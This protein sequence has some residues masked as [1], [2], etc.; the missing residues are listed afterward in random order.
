MLNSIERNV[1]NFIHLPINEIALKIGIS[2]RHVYRIIDRLVIKKI[3]R[4]KKNPS[5]KN[6]F[7]YSVCSV[8]IYNISQIEFKCNKLNLKTFFNT[9][10]KYIA[11]ILKYLKVKHKYVE[12]ILIY[13]FMKCKGLNVQEKRINM[14]FNMNLTYFKLEDIN[15]WLKYFKVLKK[16]KVKFK[17]EGYIIPDEL[18]DLLKEIKEKVKEKNSERK[19]KSKTFR[20]KYKKKEVKD[21]LRQELID[22][23]DDCFKKAYKRRNIG[24]PTAKI[25]K[26]LSNLIKYHKDEI[27]LIKDAFKDFIER[28]DYI[29]EDYKLKDQYPIFE[30]FIKIKNTFLNDVKNRQNDDEEK[31]F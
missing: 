1:C 3:I 9:H 21:S 22:L 10:Y 20:K 24:I 26:M 4:K 14:A 28:W 18:I 30:V 27:D 6:G 5:V 25:N 15:F 12:Y 17:K 31:W 11:E 13:I 7:L 29:K 23:Y 16:F 2:S 19:L 8:T